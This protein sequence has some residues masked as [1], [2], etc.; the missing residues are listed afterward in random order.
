[1]NS[2]TVARRGE[3]GGSVV[4]QQAGPLARLAPD[5]GQFG[6]RHRVSLTLAVG[7]TDTD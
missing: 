2:S 7:G 6:Q 4:E 5:V 3:L 1:V